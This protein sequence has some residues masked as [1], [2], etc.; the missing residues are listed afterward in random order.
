MRLPKCP[1]CGS[2][3]D[4]VTVYKNDT[5]ELNCDDCGY[6]SYVIPRDEGETDDAF[7]ARAIDLWTEDVKIPLCPFC[8]HEVQE[9]D[10]VELSARSF[11]ND[12]AVKCAD[13]DATGPSA[14]SE[15]EAFVKWIDRA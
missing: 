7:F 9:D 4:I 10:I 5:I 15:S 12:V 11:R 3:G 8:E 2:V 13:C 1:E 14:I 6:A